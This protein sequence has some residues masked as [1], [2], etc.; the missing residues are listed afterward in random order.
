MCN[1]C[2]R[3]VD[4]GNATFSF[5]LV[6][7][8]SIG[9]TLLTVILFN[10]V[11]ESFLGCSATIYFELTEKSSSFSS[12]VAALLEGM[13]VTMTLRTPP[14]SSSID[15]TFKKDPKV[16]AIYPLFRPHGNSPLV[17]DAIEL[18]GPTTPLATPAPL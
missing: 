7:R 12:R 8:C 4:S 6:L 18:A 10:E 1:V 11:V 3:P 2:S 15:S 9:L 16:V 14:T 5:K 13:H 17:N